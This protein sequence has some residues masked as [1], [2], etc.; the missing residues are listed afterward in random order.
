VQE[1]RIEARAGLGAHRLRVLNATSLDAPTRTRERVSWNQPADLGATRAGRAGTVHPVAARRA[2]AGTPF[3][4]AATTTRT[5]HGAP[6]SHS[7]FMNRRK[8]VSRHPMIRKKRLGNLESN[9][10]HRQ[11][12]T[13]GSIQA[14]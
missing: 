8:E 11:L 4:S 9:I 13:Y 14:A 1:H 2:R 3:P 6:A 12:R 7:T 5:V 10:R